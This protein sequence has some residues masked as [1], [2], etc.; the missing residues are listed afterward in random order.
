[1][2]R[3]KPGQKA[4]PSGRKP[5]ELSREDVAAIWHDVFN[6][7]RLRDV[8][9]RLHDVAIEKENPE[10]LRYIVDRGLGRPK[11]AV[12]LTTDGQAMQMQVYIPER[13]KREDE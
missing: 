2:P 12:D 3:L 9:T 1:M 8:F 6:E 5:R 10:L 7:K 4:K 13:R 11:E